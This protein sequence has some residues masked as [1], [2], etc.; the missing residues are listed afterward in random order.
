MRTLMHKPH[1]KKII[2]RGDHLFS[3][4]SLISLPVL[5]V[6]CV[7]WYYERAPL[8]NIECSST[9]VVQAGET[10]HLDTY[11]TVS[12][13]SGR[14]LYSMWLEDSKGRMVYEYK[15]VK[16]RDSSF[17]F[18]NQNITLPQ[19]LAPGK[20]SLHAELQYPLNPFKTATVSADLAN[21]EVVNLKHKI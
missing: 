10:A 15:P 3:I 9:L 21:L 8:R 12:F 4:T 17:T 14:A 20:Y 7:Y 5:L 19:Q 2:K 6:L 18:G 16:V 11:Y 1:V 13:S